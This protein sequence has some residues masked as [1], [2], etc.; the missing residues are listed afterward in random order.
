MK[1]EYLLLS[2]VLVVG[3][4]GVLNGGGSGETVLYISGDE[5]SSFG[6]PLGSHMGQIG[7]RINYQCHE[8]AEGELVCCYP[9]GDELYCE[10][11]DGTSFG[12]NKEFREGGE[13]AYFNSPTKPGVF[14]G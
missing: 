12:A 14:F 10:T 2:M 3:L 13:K 1:S 4:A 5:Q 9:E 11:G 8:N 6:R 7:S